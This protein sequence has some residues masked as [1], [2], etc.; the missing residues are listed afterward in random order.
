MKYIPFNVKTDYYLLQSLIKME[1]L[2]LF[3]I[4]N[5]VNLV[6]ICDN[7]LSGSMEFFLNLQKYNLKG[8]LGLEVIVDSKILYLYASNYEGYKKLLKINTI[9]QTTDLKIDDVLSKDLIVVINYCDYEILKIGNYFKDVFIG[10]T[11]KLEKEEALSKNLNVIYNRKINVLEKNDSYVLKYLN[12]MGGLN[13]LSRPSYLEE[14]DAKKEEEYKTF[15]SKINV[16]IPKGNLHIPRYSSSDSDYLYQ[17][18]IKGLKKRLNSEIPKDYYDRLMYELK[19]INE[20][21]FTSYFLIVY[22]YVLYAKKNNILVG[23]GRGS[24]AGSLVCYSIGITDIDPVEYDLLF[25]RFLNIDRLTMPDID[26]DFDNTKR[27]EIINYVREKYGV[28]K[29]AVGLTYNTFKTKLV[30][31]ELAKIMKLDNYLF[32]KFL[33]VIDR[34]LSLS[35]NLKHENIVTYLKTYTELEELYK[36]SMKLEN[37]KKNR[38]T[39]AAGVVICDKNIDDLIPVYIDDENY[40]CGFT[41]DYLEDLGILKMDFLG[42]KNLSIISSI[43]EETNVDLNSINLSDP[44]V[45]N[46]FTLGKTDGIF[47][48]ETYAMKEL[49]RKL[50]PTN[51]NEIIAAVALVRPGPNEFL[52]EYIAGKNNPENIKYPKLLENVLKETYGIILYQE[53]I[54][55]ILN[56]VG[57]F[58][59][60][61]A[62]IVR[63]AISKKMLRGIEGSKLKFVENAIKKGYDQKEVE[64]L[65]N[66]IEKFA[67]YGFNKSH[68]VAYALIGYQMAYLKVKHAKFFIKELLKGSKDIKFIESYINEIKS[69]NIPVLK[70]DINYSETDF[71]I[72]NEKLILPLNLISGVNSE[73]EKSILLNKPYEDFFDFCLK[74]ANIKKEIIENLIYAGALRSFKYNIKTLINNMDKAMIYTD[75]KGFGKKPIIT[76]FDEYSDEELSNYEY[77]MYG[78]Y[79]SNHPS[80]KFLNSNI[81]KLRNKESNLF[82]NVLLV[83]KVEN[84][85]SIK[86]KK[87][88]DMAFMSISDET[89]TDDVVVFNDVYGKLENIQKGN[90][91]KINGKIGKNNDKIN[92]VLNDIKRME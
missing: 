64:M 1:D 59:N 92:I 52:D 79:I 8:A 42:L 61:E 71:H 72:I 51:F 19:V 73:V 39:H 55:K 50:K 41:M 21:G 37:L 48:Y 44:E 34:N 14:I 46:I 57:D 38:S 22:D 62:D 67:G 32:E 84:I 77:L 5:E 58:S 13:D 35:D 45:I 11:T 69:K 33:K 27:E 6:S 75:L 88:D 31:R 9:M 74:N 30:L 54:I 53:Q 10:Y 28:K 15:F 20:M 91:V 2:F 78:F 23:P 36:V 4:K 47:Q 26:I 87:G 3:C 18:S 7:N 49:L 29:V 86:T 17:L 85:K 24:A 65:F 89:G 56:I 60:S 16:E 82:K 63:R 12:E 83:V 66:K 25:E 40:K 81:M 90:L 70:P 80:S 76:E 68:S 43:I